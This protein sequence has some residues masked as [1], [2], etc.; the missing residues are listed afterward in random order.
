MIGAMVDHVSKLRPINVYTFE[1]FI[2]IY[3]S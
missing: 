2:L 1:E 3:R